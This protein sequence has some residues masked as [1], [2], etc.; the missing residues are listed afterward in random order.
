MVSFSF[1]IVNIDNSSSS[2]R[3]V[4]PGDEDDEP[5]N[6]KKPRKAPEKQLTLCFEKEDPHVFLKSRNLTRVTDFSKI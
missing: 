6:G 4:E 2:I 5:K 1:N 3:Q